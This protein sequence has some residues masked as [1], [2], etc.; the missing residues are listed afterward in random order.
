LG[1]AELLVVIPEN[2]GFTLSFPW[3][4]LQVT[5]LEKCNI[6]KKKDEVVLVLD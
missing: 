1:K 2:E 5:V 6:I 3:S 4:C